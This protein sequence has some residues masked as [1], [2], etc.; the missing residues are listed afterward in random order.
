[1]FGGVS[2]LSLDNKGRLAIPAKHREALSAEFGTTL[3]VTLDSSDCLLLY[4]EKNWLPVQARVNALPTSQPTVRQFQRLVLGHAETVD[5]D[6]AGR[7]LLAA[8]LRTMVDLDKNVVLVG[9]GHR[10][11]L[12]DEAKWDAQTAAALA[13]PADSLAAHLGDFS[14]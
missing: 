13:L 9:M 8:K 14:L 1:M 10:F 6:G 3:V 4:P 5:M 11:E 12:W 2:L 7:I